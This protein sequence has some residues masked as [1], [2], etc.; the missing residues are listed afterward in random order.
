MPGRITQGDAIRR[1][2]IPL[3]LI[4]SRLL[5]ELQMLSKGRY[6]Y[7][8]PEHTYYETDVWA[9]GGW[10]DGANSIEHAW[11][12][13]CKQRETDKFWCFFPQSQNVK[14]LSRNSFMIDVL[15]ERDGLRPARLAVVGDGTQLFE[16]TPGNWDTDGNAIQNAVRQAI[17]PIGHHV[18]WVFH[19]NL[20]LSYPG[21]TIELY[22]PVVATTAQIYVV[23]DGV[24]WSE[25]LKFQN[26]ADCF[27]HQP[28][29]ISAFTTP[30]Y[31]TRFWSEAITATLRDMFRNYPMGFARSKYLSSFQQDQEDTYKRVAAQL[32][33]NMPTR[34]LLVEADSL[35]TT[36]ATYLNELNSAVR[37]AI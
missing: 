8:D 21:Q 2:G 5:P 36:L 3:E 32:T 23:K 29:V 31:V 16:K 19:R 35:K 15:K 10:T 34:V 22:L 28:A 13:E 1:S 6:L 11:F 7:D 33:T 37:A 9:L 30:G 24:E 4:V 12:V 25:L 26:L 17:M 18:R 27:E 14:E 20:L